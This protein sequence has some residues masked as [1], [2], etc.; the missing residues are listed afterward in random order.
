MNL[1]TTS[2]IGDKPELVSLPIEGMSHTDLLTIPVRPDVF[3][4][5]VII[6]SQAFDNEAMAKSVAMDLYCV[7]A[8]AIAERA[9][10]IVE[11]VPLGRFRGWNAPERGG[12]DGPSPSAA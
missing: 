10:Q 6:M 4:R 12:S 5:L 9:R 1:V 3:N 2:G 7:G 8:E 11:E